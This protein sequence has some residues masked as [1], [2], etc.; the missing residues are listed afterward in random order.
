ME[1]R[2]REGRGQCLRVDAGEAELRDLAPGRFLQ[3]D[4]LL[5]LSQGRLPRAALAL[6]EE[7]R[8]LRLADGSRGGAPLL[9]LIVVAELCGSLRGR[10][11]M[12]MLKM[13]G[14][15]ETG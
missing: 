11:R 9:L 5:C 7:A 1:E 8:G 13:G 3:L 12:K 6:A 10:A 15:G 4:S 2:V 14:T